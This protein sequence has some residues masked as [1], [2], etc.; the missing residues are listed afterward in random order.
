MFDI[1]RPPFEAGVIRNRLETDPP[2]GSYGYDL[3][4]LEIVMAK[5]GLVEPH[6]RISELQERFRLA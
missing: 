6:L 2:I 3:E 4:H 1:V 5:L